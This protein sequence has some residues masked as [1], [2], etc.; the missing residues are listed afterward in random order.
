MQI[1]SATIIIPT[2]K[3]QCPYSGRSFLLEDAA[4][5][6]IQELKQTKKN[7]FTHQYL[8]QVAWEMKVYKVYQI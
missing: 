1:H 5:K 2:D 7:Y 6:Q 3:E 4:D 8:D